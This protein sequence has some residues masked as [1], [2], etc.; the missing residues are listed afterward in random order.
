MPPRG[1]I[2]ARLD[3]IYVR[4]VSSHAPARGHPLWM[5]MD[6]LVEK[7]QVMPPRGGIVNGGVIVHNC[8]DVSSHAPARGHLEYAPYQELGTIV[9]SHA[10]AR[11]HRGV[12]L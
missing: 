7:F 12:V 8:M 11:G 3:E 6:I 4:K 10:P 1:G 2:I 5:M 9:S